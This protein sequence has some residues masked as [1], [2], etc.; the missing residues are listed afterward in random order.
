[1][2]HTGPEEKLLLCSAAMRRAHGLPDPDHADGR[3]T[4]HAAALPLHR[5]PGADGNSSNRQKDWI[6]ACAGMTPR[7]A[8]RAPPFPVIPAQAGIQQSWGR[9][10]AVAECPWRKGQ[11]NGAMAVTGR[12]PMSRSLKRQR[13]EFQRPNSGDSMLNSLSMAVD[14]VFSRVL[15]TSLTDASHAVKGKKYTVP[16]IPE[17]PKKYPLPYSHFI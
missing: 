4:R 11:F 6:P 5:Q 2:V 8:N 15:D 7:K 16:G 9:S 13:T 10:R 14:V 12:F 3:R 17:I 1:M